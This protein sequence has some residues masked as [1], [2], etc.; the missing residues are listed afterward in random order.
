MILNRFSW[1]FVSKFGNVIAV[2]PKYRNTIY[3]SDANKKCWYYD[4]ENVALIIKYV[5]TG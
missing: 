5:D 3:R 1:P 4:D 2:D